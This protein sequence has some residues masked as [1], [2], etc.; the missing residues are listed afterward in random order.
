M[1]K[2]PALVARFLHKDDDDHHDTSVNLKTNRQLEEENTCPAMLMHVNPIRAENID[3]HWRVIVQDL[4]GVHQRER[5]I[6]CLDTESICG[7][8]DYEQCHISR[9]SQQLRRRRLLAYDPCHPERG[10]FVDV[11]HF[12]SACSCHNSPAFPYC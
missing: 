12:Q 11:F 7:H 8:I 9:C 2:K 10:I 1:E 5:I 6:V 4:K 3:G